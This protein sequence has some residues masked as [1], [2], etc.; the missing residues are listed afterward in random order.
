MAQP[1]SFFFKRDPHLTGTGDD[2]DKA[3]EE[4]KDDVDPPGGRCPSVGTG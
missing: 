4:V 1:F 3:K 2:D